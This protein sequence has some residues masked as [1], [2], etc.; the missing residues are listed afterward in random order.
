M[1]ISNIE[2]LMLNVEVEDPNKIVELS[3]PCQLVNLLTY[4]L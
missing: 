1:R 2:Y 4:Q 3:F